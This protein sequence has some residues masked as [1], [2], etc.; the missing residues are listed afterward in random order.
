MS[1]AEAIKSFKIVAMTTTGCAKY[2]TILEQNN[3]ETIIIEEAAEV[4]ESHVLSLLTKNTKQL[5]LIGDHKQLKPKPYNYELETKYNFN[6]SM[7]ERLINNNIPYAALKYQRRMKP[8][9]ADFVRIIYGDTVY[10]DHED[11]L[12]KESVKGIENDMYI[13]THDKLEGENEGLKSKQNDY[14]AMYL[15]KLCQYLLKQGYKNEQITILTFYVGQVLLIKKYMK[16][17]GLNDVRVSSVDNYQGEECDII[18]LSLVR[19][20]RKFEIGFLRNFNR[21]CVSFSRAKIGLYIIGNID[22]IVKGEILF[23]NKNMDNI[24]KK[25]DPKM[26]EVWEKIQE[27]AKKLNIIGDKLTLV[28]QNHK[29]KTI[30]STHKDFENCPEGGCQQICRKRMNCGHACEKTCHVYDCNSVKC[31]KPCKKLNPN[32]SLKI[33]ICNKRC[34]EDCG[35]CEA[36]VDKE[37]PCGHIKKDCKCFENINEIQC[38]EKCSKILR[39]GHNCKLNCCEDCYSKPCKEKIKVKLPTCGHI[40]EIECYMLSDIN[41][42]ICQEKCKVVLPCGHNC[43]G[44]CGKCL[45]GTL[46]VKCGFKC[47]RNL[48]CGHVCSQKCS[49]E[50]LCEQNCPNICDH[51][52]CCLKCCEICVPCEEDC[53]FKY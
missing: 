8:K 11:V 49:A 27:K 37:L 10:I 45:E 1:D 35:R 30:I 24:G 52:Y 47:G 12:H 16:K 36:K 13:I 33:H 5:I 2:S 22:C 7:F 20:N 14:E 21:V 3:F 39:C 53:I 50:C 29:N 9:F 15:T 19:S 26:L 32:C 17:F 34:Y 44:T 38:I 28:C 40:N 43:Q 41:Q 31:L 46:H 25:I 23:K 18:L 4:L 42:I 48:P 51:G 6:V